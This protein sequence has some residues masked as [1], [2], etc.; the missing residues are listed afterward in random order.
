MPNVYSASTINKAEENMKLEHI[1]LNVPDP[2]NAA[3]WYVENLGM[4]IVRAAD[5]SPYIHFLADNEGP[6]MIE[7]Y[8]N[9]EAAVPDY[10]SQS[11]LTLHIAFAVEDMEETRTGLLAA[12]A[13][14][15]GD[16]VRRANGDQLAMLRDPWGVS[17]QLVK[18]G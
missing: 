12:G 13:T 17:L 4:K 5:K 18:R 7:M 2:V 8:N 11:P 10:L 3:K 14:A 16:V 1:A 9:P 15:E 6:V